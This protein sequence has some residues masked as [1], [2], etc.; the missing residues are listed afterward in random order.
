L[1]RIKTLI[2]NKIRKRRQ[3]KKIN[4]EE[5]VKEKEREEAREGEKGF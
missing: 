5:M 4:T 3:T 2:E 1:S